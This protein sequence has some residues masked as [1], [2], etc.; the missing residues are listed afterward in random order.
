M[1]NSKQTFKTEETANFSPSKRSVKSRSKSE[2]STSSK[3][4]QDDDMN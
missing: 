3:K 1:R 4:L 2:S